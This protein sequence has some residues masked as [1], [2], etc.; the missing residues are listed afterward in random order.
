M[1]RSQVTK[2]FAIEGALYAVTASVVGVAVGVGVGW[3]LVQVL[4]QIFFAETAFLTFGFAMQ[5]ESLML[6]AAVGLG[7]TMITI[8]F[9]AIRISS[10]NVIAAVRD[11]PQPPTRRGRARVVILSLVG[12]AAGAGLA[13]VGLTQDVQAAAMAGVPLAA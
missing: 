4:E 7:I 8:W 3:V 9:T 5:P 6:A 13:Y 1:S 2:A 12:L 10:F 11:L